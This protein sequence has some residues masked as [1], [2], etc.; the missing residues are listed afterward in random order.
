M[1][2]RA[3]TGRDGAQP[4]GMSAAPAALDLTFPANAGELGPTRRALRRWLQQMGVPADTAQDV[5]TATAEACANAV[6]HAYRGAPDGSVR[7]RADLRGDALHVVIADDGSWKD[8][9]RSPDRGRGIVMM[10]AMMSGVDVA[11]GPSGTTVT[12]WRILR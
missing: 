9:D 11:H 2:T 7:L 8:S 12:L 6:E 1:E 3:G 10:R 4:S 5:V